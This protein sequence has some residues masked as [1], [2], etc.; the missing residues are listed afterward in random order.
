MLSATRAARRAF[1][2]AAL[3]VPEPPEAALEPSRPPA[4][5]GGKAMRSG[6]CSEGPLAAAV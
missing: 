6:A 1:A 2:S 3:T 5:G 4:A